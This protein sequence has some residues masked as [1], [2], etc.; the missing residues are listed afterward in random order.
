MEHNT[1]KEG[2]CMDRKLSQCQKILAYMEKHG[3]ITPRDADREFGC[4]RLASRMTDLKQRGYKFTK[5]M[6]KGRDRDGKPC[7]YARYRLV[8]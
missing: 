3:S 5:E 2:I 8:D 4:M 6:E 1:E 7:R